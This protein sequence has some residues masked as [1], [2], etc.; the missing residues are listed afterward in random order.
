[1]T[2]PGRT[3]PAPSAGGY[4]FLLSGTWLGG[5]A[6]ALALAAIMVLLGQWQ[7]S[8]YQERTAINARIDAAATE[9]PRPLAAVLP[10]PAAGQAVGPA[11]PEDAAGRSV[12]ATGRYDV[13]NEILVRG[14]T[15]LGRVG[16]EVV[17]PLVLADGSAVLIDRGWVPPAPGGASALPEVPPA[18]AGGV[19][20][21]GRVHPTESGGAPVTR[22]DGWLETRRIT[23][24]RLAAHLPHRLYHAYVLL[25]TQTPPLDAGLTPIPLRREPAWQNGGYAV[26]WW[27]FA[28]LVLVGY[29]WL[30]RREARPRQTPDGPVRAGPQ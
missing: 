26:Q 6:A 17:T 30:A 20:V 10:A 16:F 24:A 18:P 28:A 13:A 15:V 22:R 14:R 29:V 21:V 12:T 23:T 9:Q 2:G 19:T 3:G 11:P 7:L 8:R 27:L 4:R 1:M 5:L 25:D